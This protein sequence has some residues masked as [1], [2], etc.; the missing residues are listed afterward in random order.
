MNAG[1]EPPHWHDLLIYS[2][3]KATDEDFGLAEGW[4]NMVDKMSD[5]VLMPTASGHI[6]DPFVIVS[7][8]QSTTNPVGNFASSSQTLFATAALDPLHFGM[9]VS[10]GGNTHISAKV[11]S[12]LNAAASL[13]LKSWR[14][15]S[16]DNMASNSRDDFGAQATTIPSSSHHLLM[17]ECINFYEA[18]LRRSP[19]LKEQGGQRKEKLH[20]TWASKF[21]RVITMFTLFFLFVS[22]FKVTAPSYA[23]SPNVTYIDCMVSRTHELNELYDGKLNWIVAYAFSTVALDMPNNEVF[24]YTKAI[25]QP[26]ADNFIG[27]LHKEINDHKSCDRWEIVH[28]NTIPPGMKTIQAIWSFKHKLFPDGTLNKHKACLCAHGSMQQWGVSY[29]ETYSPVVKILTVCLLLALCY[30]HGLHSESINFVLAF[31]QAN[32]DMDIWME[33]PMGIIINSCASDSGGYVLKLKKSLYGLKQASL[34]WFE[35]LKQSLTDWGFCP[36]EIDPCLYLKQNMILLTYVDGCIIFSPSM[37]SINHLV[38]S[39]HDGPENFQLTD[40]GDVNKFLGIKIT[41]IGKKLF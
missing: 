32:L 9:P 1:T 33:L 3:E 39:I 12:S 30:I 29:W 19:R 23:L 36:S 28:R 38:K 4:M 18:G 11:N 14:L 6:T 20:I 41:K 8:G 37:Q 31:P 22:D 15:S 25:Q 34:N 27:A 24:T 10:K 7:E 2:S 17:P 26:D 40:E 35:K 5:Q 21:P 16:T 13:L